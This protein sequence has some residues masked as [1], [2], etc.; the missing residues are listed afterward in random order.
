[1]T[2]EEV[3]SE[4]LSRL[5]K[6][7]LAKSC[8]GLKS[9]ID[10]TAT[11]IER[12]TVLANHAHDLLGVA[13]P[14]EFLIDGNRTEDDWRDACKEWFSDYGQPLSGTDRK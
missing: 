2:R 3:M 8:M 4:V 1:M 7:R 5:R 13:E 10:D 6:V 12:L 11:E 9:L 14:D